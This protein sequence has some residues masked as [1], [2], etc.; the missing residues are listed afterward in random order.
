MKGNHQILCSSNN[1]NNSQ[2]KIKEESHRDNLASQERKTI[3]NS[4]N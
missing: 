3:I 2:I 1:N 4:H